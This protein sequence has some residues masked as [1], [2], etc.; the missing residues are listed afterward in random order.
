MQVS[1]PSPLRRSVHLS[2]RRR[3]GSSTP[4]SRRWRR[5]GPRSP[6]RSATRTS[7]RPRTLTPRWV[8]SRR[9]VAVGPE[10]TDRLKPRTA[11]AYTARDPECTHRAHLPRDRGLSSVGQRPHL[12]HHLRFLQ[13]RL[14]L[15]RYSYPHTSARRN[16]VLSPHHTHAHLSTRSGFDAGPLAEQLSAYTPVPIPYKAPI[17][18]A[19]HATTAGFVLIALSSIRVLLPVIRSRWA[20]AAGIVLTSLV[21]TSG[22]MFVRIRGMPQAGQNGQ[23][24]AQGYQNQFGQEVQ[25]VSFICA[26]TAALRLSC[27]R[28]S[29]PVHRRLAV[30][31]LPHAHSHH[32]LPIAPVP[33]APAG[34]PLVW[35]HFRHVLRPHLS[36]PRQ[37]P[38]LPVQASPV[39]VDGMHVKRLFWSSWTSIYTIPCCEGKEKGASVGAI[40]YIT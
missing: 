35:S 31:V 40:S 30:G 11:R 37:E 21:M 10:C 36:L 22:F 2:T 39:D 27:T 20:W 24:I 13:V 19:K 26:C 23:W 7:S 25:V 38:Q 8:S 5:R 15:M 17:D 29:R 12:A 18:W 9:C 4:R 14:L 16:S 34:L 28:S 6:S 3:T 32:A 1:L 33:P